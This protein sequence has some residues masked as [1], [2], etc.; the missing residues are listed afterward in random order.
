MKKLLE[1]VKIVTYDGDGIRIEAITPTPRGP[2]TMFKF[3][4][5]PNRF[6]C[7]IRD[8]GDIF[9]NLDPQYE[10]ERDIIIDNFEAIIHSHYYEREISINCSVNNQDY[11][12]FFKKAGFEVVQEFENPKTNNIVYVMMYIME[13]YSGD[14]Y[15]NIL[16]PIEEEVSPITNEVAPP[17]PF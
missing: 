13:K 8:I 12:N 11:V 4:S 1:V 5:K 15:T 17:L 14:A 7:G 16:F 6:C 3:S 2:V 10:V 9:I